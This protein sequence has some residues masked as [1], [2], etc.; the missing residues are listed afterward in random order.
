MA[1]RNTVRIYDGLGNSAISFQM[2]VNALT[3]HL[4]GSHYK[5]V[6]ITPDEIKEGR[7]ISQFMCYELF[8]R[9]N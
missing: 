4:E 5:V 3:R 8:R 2:L 9:S 6:T 1:A 7:Y